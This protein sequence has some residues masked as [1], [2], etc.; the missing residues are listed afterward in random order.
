MGTRLKGWIV[1]VA[2]LAAGIAIFAGLRAGRTALEGPPRPGRDAGAV[3]VV[4]VIVD[5]ERADVT[6]TYGHERL[7]TPFLSSLARRGVRFTHAYSTGPWTVPSMYSIFTGLY[8]SQHGMTSGAVQG[9]Q[10]QG[11]KVLPDEAVT[12]TERLHEAGYATFGVCTNYH[13]SRRFGFGQGFDHFVGED[14]AFLPFPNLAVESLLDRIHGSGRYF[15]WLHYLDPHHPYIPRSPWFE[16]WNDS[17]LRSYGELTL[18]ATLDRYHA[19]RQVPPGEPVLRSDVALVDKMVKMLGLHP[20]LMLRHLGE[21]GV[22]PRPSWVRF[23]RAAYE[24]EVRNVDEAMEE[25]LGRLGIDDGTLVIVTADHGEEIYDHGSL[26]HRSNRSLHEEL[27]HVPLVVLLPG[28]EHA[29][30][31]IDDPVSLVDLYPTLLDL[32]GL[33][34]PGDLPGRSLVPLIEAGQ[35]PP[36]PVFSEVWDERRRTSCV[37]RYPWKY[38]RIPTMDGDAL[39]N[40]EE[41]PGERVDLLASEPAIASDL[42]SELIRWSSTLEPRWDAVEALPLSPEEVKRLK[43]LGYIQ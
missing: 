30:E 8:A 1:P 35:W 23:L 29:G 33:P 2:I 15:L 14:F 19:L 20:F 43:L 37:I 26:G 34:V 3:D 12:L 13:V 40:L 24:S 4:L 41:D 42:E 28:R 6:S 22:A 32:L 27:I 31:V 38:V 7:T 36:G 10:V 17:G 25:A 39:Y 18:E 16:R 11:Q 9:F 21:M 5:T